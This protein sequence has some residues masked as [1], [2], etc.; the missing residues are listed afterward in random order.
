MKT[1][2]L[3]QDC[4]MI[5]IV[6]IERGI[7]LTI[8]YY[9]LKKYNNLI[10]KDIIIDNTNYCV[11]FKKL[12]PKLNFNKFISHKKNNFYFNIRKI[13]KNQD[14]IIDYLINYENIIYT[15]KISLLPWYDMNDVIIVYEYNKHKKL[16]ISKFKIF[17]KNFS[18]CRRGNYNN[19][20]WDLYIENIILKKYILF[21]KQINIQ[22]FFN[23]INT[24][25]KSNYT[26]TM[27]D[28]P[29][30]YYIEKFSSNNKTQPIN[31]SSQ[32]I[33]N[34]SQSINNTNTNINLDNKNINLVDTK[35]IKIEDETKL[36][37]LI[38][39]LNEKLSIIN[40]IL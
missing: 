22:Y 21:N 29:I 18:S 34:S 19:E 40:K 6:W 9:I 39:I 20:I 3:N 12:F 5:N 36:N 13:I 35:N 33:N 14:I 24:F 8:I 16:E 15:E 27:I 11:F 7:I 25:I 10:K 38:E 37:E 30:I 2:L 32:P 28:R 23:L 17:I 4:K 26:N 31:N 1:I